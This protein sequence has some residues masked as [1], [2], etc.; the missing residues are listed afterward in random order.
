MESD[1]LARDEERSSNAAALIEGLLRLSQIVRLRFNDWLSDF[2]LN[3]GRHSVLVALSRSGDFGCSQAEMADKLCQSESNVSTLIERMERDGLVSRSRSEADR[4]KRVLRITSE[5]LKTLS[6]VDAKRS[7]WATRL[8]QGV[9]TTDVPD[10]ALLLQRLGS[11][12][13]RTFAIPQSMSTASR[14][15]KDLTDRG[16][17]NVAEHPFASADDP[18]SP[19]FALRQM[20][21]ELSAG[22][23][24]HSLGAYGRESVLNARGGVASDRH[25][26]PHPQHAVANE[27]EQAAG[28]DLCG[29]DAA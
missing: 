11:S 28:A 18:S 22:A 20:L 16:V 8:L 19:Q 3:D 25:F 2:N 21:L 17:N 4:R 10:L 6:A 24:K 1:G 15:L 7:I 23:G 9:P 26:E 14:P 12:L 29:K 13:D 5:G 27:I